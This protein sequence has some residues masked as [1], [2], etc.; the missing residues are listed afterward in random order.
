MMLVRNLLQPL[1]GSKKRIVMLL[2]ILLVFLACGS[3]KNLPQETEVVEIVRPDKTP[4]VVVD[5]PSLPVEVIN[6]DTVKIDSSEIEAPQKENYTI[7]V[8]LPFKLNQQNLNPIN[9]Q[10]AKFDRSTKMAV[11]FYQGFQM[12][13]NTIESS[14]VRIEFVVLD[15]EN[16]EENVKQL[17]SRPPFPKVDLVV[18]PV[19]NKTLRVAA[20]YCEENKI[21][22][23]SPLSSSTSITSENPYYYT[24]NATRTAHYEAMLDYIHSTYPQDTLH[25]IHGNTPKERAVIDEVVS[26]NQERKDDT[27][28][29]MVEIP[30][31][32]EDDFETIKEEF[33]SLDNH[34]VF[35][36]STKESYTNYALSQLAN[37]KLYWSSVVFGMPNWTKFKNINYDYFEWL[38]LHLTQSYW[39]NENNFDV[40]NFDR[41]FKA[42]YKMEPSEYAYQGYDLANFVLYSIAKNA[43]K[44]QPNS[45][46]QFFVDHASENGLQTKFEFVP[47]RNEQLS[48][49]YWDNNFIHLVK[50]ENY[51]FNKLK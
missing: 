51:R 15:T 39:L 2:P 20:T 12:A 32:M 28:T 13:I 41:D 24:A 50:F 6:I 31:D 3:T 46:E 30:F 47:R 21:P 14:D 5:T 4:E 49:D 11:E 16:S 25:I 19:Y 1:S 37:I 44:D 22:I 40:V 8:L 48:I 29:V 27:P 17:F 43:A 38:E 18:G 36:P 45:K 42:Q 33:D 35:V 34:L 26:I 9:V 23:I 10:E 7:A